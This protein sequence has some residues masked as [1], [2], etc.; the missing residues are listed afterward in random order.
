M[1]ARNPYQAAPVAAT[2]ATRAASGAPGPPMRRSRVP[3]AEDPGFRPVSAD[4]PLP[5]NDHRLVHEGSRAG[6]RELAGP[7]FA[8]GPAR[9]SRPPRPQ[10]IQL[11]Q[12]PRG[13]CSSG[14]VAGE[15]GAPSR[16]TPGPRKRPAEDRVGAEGPVGR[17]GGLDAAAAQPDTV[18]SCH[19]PPLRLRLLPKAWPGAVSPT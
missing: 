2:T 15:L 1:W 13:R 3:A 11:R 17:T 8:T 12:V 19:S 14:E 5:A 18:T 7:W 4:M 6:P 10:G 9:L 16:T